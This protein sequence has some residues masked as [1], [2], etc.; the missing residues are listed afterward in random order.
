MAEREHDENANGTFSMVVVNVK[1]FRSDCSL[2]WRQTVVFRA[3]L[4]T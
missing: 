4:L 1:F 2:L 3:S